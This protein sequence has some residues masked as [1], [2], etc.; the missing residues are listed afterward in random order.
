[1]DTR[2]L[3]LLLNTLLLCG[4]A[5][6]ISLPLGTALAWLLV[7]TDLPG[8]RVGLILLGLM[9][10]VPLYLQTAAWQA[11]F[12]IQGWYTLVADAPAWL[13]GFRGAVWVH[14]MAAVPWVVLIVGVGLWLVEPELEEQT[15]LD[16]SSRQVFLRVTLRGAAP[17]V[18]VAA[19]WVAIV[20]AGEMTVTDLFMVR[21]Y[22]EELYTQFAI[23]PD[24]DAAPLGVWPGVVLT[25]LLVAAGLTVCS[26]LAPRNRPLTLRRRW[27]FP[28]GPW[29]IPAAVLAAAVL[30]L[31]VGLPLLNL[32][33]KAGVQV[34][35]LDVERVRTFSPGKCFSIV[36]TSPW[37][38]RRELGWSLAIGTLAAT[39]AVGA[40]TPLAW[41]ARSG[42][43]R[44]VPVLVVM[45][46]CLALPGPLVALGLIRLLNRPEFPLL[47]FL[48][49]RSV[50]APWLALL[51]RSLPLATLVM[52]HALRTVPEEMLDSAA[53]D[54]AGP[55]GRLC[56]VALPCR[57][58]AVAL[59]WVVAL[60]VA[61]GDLAASILVVP[62]GVTT[63]S[64][65]IFDLLHSGV[66]D[67]VAGI[68]LALVVLFA[69]SAAVA[70]GLVRRLSRQP[71]PAIKG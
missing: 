47:V 45:A 36:I 19:L 57:L 37:Q 6:G 43:R 16:G 42:K 63:L 39:A 41:F 50:L 38:Y 1:M 31:L 40:A 53:V 62:P 21:T 7:R 64:I 69:V 34:T 17:A 55:L 15:L 44:G 5:C 29:K 11:G 28:L 35:Q 65:Q 30:A 33:Y 71:H 54:G 32:C 60:A 61:L 14:A 26:E 27:V 51:V 46:V 20:A 56:R 23:G 59:A 12:G 68:S 18:G 4:A 52:W 48:Y 58:S 70:A 25:V 24:V 22:A 10:F 8:R 3:T 67:Q 13:D 2:T 49:D 9:L 66:E